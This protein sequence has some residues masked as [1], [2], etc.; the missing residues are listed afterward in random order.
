MYLV[1]RIV[2]VALWS[3]PSTP[4]AKTS[5]AEAVVGI[6]EALAIAILSYAEHTK[7]I[8]PSILLNLYLLLS[9]ILDLASA[10]TYFLRHGLGAIAGVYTVALVAKVILFAL[11]EYPKQPIIKEKDTP[12][13]TA[14]GVVSRGIFWWMNSLLYNGARALLT[15]HDIG[16]I[17]DKFSSRKLLDQLE[18]VWDEG[19]YTGV[20]TVTLVSCG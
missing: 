16:T 19:K 18:K 7:S 1:L 14:A 9:C 4:K 5:I 15:V 3:L 12:S 6:L 8:R 11:E 13:E 17:E 2:L 20:S 10:R